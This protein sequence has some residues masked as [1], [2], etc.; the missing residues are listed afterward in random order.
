MTTGER[1]LIG[2]IVT[3]LGW[4]SAFM[5]GQIWV[6]SQRITK[7]EVEHTSMK[8]DLGEHRKATGRDRR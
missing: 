5:F 2:A 4:F 3:I 1:L 8:E 6:N 7:L